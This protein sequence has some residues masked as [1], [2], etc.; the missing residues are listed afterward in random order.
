MVW[1]SV[2]GV[3]L[4]EG[5]NAAL[6]GMHLCVLHSK[7]LCLQLMFEDGARIYL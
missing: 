7:Q 6:L 3:V 1:E 2:A 5:R 4:G